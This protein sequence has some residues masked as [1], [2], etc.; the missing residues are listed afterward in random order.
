MKNNKNFMSR[1]VG[2][3]RFDSFNRLALI[4]LATNG[5]YLAWLVFHIHGA[6]G[7]VFLI[8]ECLVSLVVAVFSFNHWTRH[9]QLL[10]GDYSMRASVD[11]FIP[12]VN[13]PLGMLE[14]TVAAAADIDYARKTVYLL[15]DGERKAVRK[16]AEKYDCVYL[17]RPK[18]P[19][20]QY[21]AGNLNYGLEHSN[22]D[23]VLT[24]DADNV[25]SPTILDD[26]MGHFKED[27]IAIVASRQVFTIDKGDFN[28]DHLFYNY[29]QSGKNS[30]GAAI[31]C[32]S[33]VIYRRAALNAIGGFSEWNL[34]E[35]LHTTYIANS[36]GYR[37]VYVT[38]SYVRGH[39]PTDVRMIYKQRGTW[40]LDT[41]RIFFWQ[42]PL[43]RKGL[44]WRQRLHYFEMGYC[45]LVSG[46]IL[47]AIY[48]I[49]FYLLF[50]NSLMLT[51]GWWY[52]VFR[53]PAL[54]GM[55]AF[56]GRFSQG[57]LTSQ[58][59][60]G[61]FPVYAKATVLALFHRR[62]KPLYRVT[63]KVDT[64][65]RELQLVIP[66][67]LFAAIGYSSLVFHVLH[68]GMGQMFWFGLFWT[69]LMSYWLW[70]IIKMSFAPKAPI[71]QRRVEAPVAAAG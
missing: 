18:V 26:L 69:A 70:P 55:L 47:P 65:K 13:E 50:T 44:S 28:H 22:S 64:G 52:L 49:N 63:S 3:Y 11:V 8:L 15:D 6:L 61:L 4:A 29:M 17:S 14:K 33:G 48:L 53:I 2:S 60:F 20:K 58:V 59:W 45:Y 37:S 66:Q 25:V 32:G 67:L 40:A 36:Y 42:H 56:F 12:T 57:Q 23:F 54:V 27:N 38:Q 51:G 19:G 68:Y 10:G 21:K 34:V 39:A 7:V 30:D 24:I 46:I 71:R 31:S 5:V 43:L 1:A 9:Y 41:L 16:L 62:T 35:D